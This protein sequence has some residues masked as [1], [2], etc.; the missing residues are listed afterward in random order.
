[1]Y[2]T[3]KLSIIYRESEHP[4]VLFGDTDPASLF[5]VGRGNASH[6][7]LCKFSTQSIQEILCL[8]K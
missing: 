8:E 7:V 1:M 4:S 2:V 3:Q 5:E 6:D